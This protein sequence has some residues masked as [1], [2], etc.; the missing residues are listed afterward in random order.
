MLSP[1]LDYCAEESIMAYHW[2]R[3]EE[4]VEALEDEWRVGINR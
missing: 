3:Q 1:S 4:V 2:G